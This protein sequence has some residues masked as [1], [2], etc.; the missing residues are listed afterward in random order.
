[1]TVQTTYDG[2]DKVDLVVEAVLENLKLKQDIFVELEKRCPK[3]A[4][5]ASNTSTISLADIGRNTTAQ[6]RII[7][8]HFFSP[9]HVMPLLEII[10]TAPDSKVS[11]RFGMHTD[12][13]P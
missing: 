2:F 3:H 8:L 7:G 12:A 1:V 5:L 10:R 4:I 11:E 13:S 6:D 9:A